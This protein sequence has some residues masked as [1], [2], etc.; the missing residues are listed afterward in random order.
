MSLCV[1]DRLVCRFEWDSSRELIVSIQHLVYVTLCGWSFG[2]QIWM[3]LTRRTNCFNTSSGISLCRW[4]F[5]VQ[6][7][8]I[9][10]RRTNCINTTSGICHRVDD[11]LVCR[12]GWDSSG[13][14]IVS[15]QHLVYVTLCRWS[16]GVQVWMRLIRRTNCFNTTSGIYHC[17]DDLLV[18]RFGWDSSGELIASIRHL[19]YVTPKTSE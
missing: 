16:F 17:V 8:M 5:C 7:W 19:V 3:R 1:D 15:I 4:S 6:I 11:L 18:C 14:L 9:L 10:I 13:E 12:F 2:V